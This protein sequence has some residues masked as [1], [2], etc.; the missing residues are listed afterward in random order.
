MKKL[1]LTIALIIGIA[2]CTFAQ[3]YE[4]NRGLFGRG[5]RQGSAWDWDIW[6]LGLF[7][8]F[9]EMD[10]EGGDE[11]GLVLPGEHG[12]PDDADAPLGTGIAVLTALG[13]AY[14]VSKRRR[15]E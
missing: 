3:E 15:E 10:R 6:S 11:A 14:L 5:E 7:E 13:A 2:T 1:T 12:N 4:G 9:D 8:D